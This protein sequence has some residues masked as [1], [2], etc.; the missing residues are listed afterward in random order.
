[1][2]RVNARCGFS[3]LE[4]KKHGI[5][6]KSKKWHVSILTH[7]FDVALVNIHTIYYVMHDKPEQ[8]DLLTFQANVTL[9]LLK[10][11]T[12]SEPCKRRKKGVHLPKEV[13]M[14]RGQHKMAKNIQKRQQKCKMC[15]K[16]PESNALHVML[17]L[18]WMAVMLSMSN[19][20][21]LNITNWKN[22]LLWKKFFFWMCFNWCRCIIDISTK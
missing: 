16:M 6:I 2:Q 8:V 13:V 7:C 10:M 3:W 22:T 12:S 5:G 20:C 14:L 11:D 21:L 9:C 4:N 18:G 19:N 15:E 17:A 1:M